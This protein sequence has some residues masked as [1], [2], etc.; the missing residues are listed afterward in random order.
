M[1]YRKKI[2]YPDFQITRDLY[3]RGGE[4]MTT[5]SRE[6]VGPY[7][8][9]TDGSAFTLGSYDEVRSKQLVP[10]VRYAE[11]QMGTYDAI[12]HRK[13][14]TTTPVPPH[15][16]APSP[17]ERSRG[18]LYRYFARKVTD[19]SALVTEVSEKTHGLL[20]GKSTSQAV[21][22]QTVRIVWRIGPP[23][24][25]RVVNGITIPG[26]VDENL[27]AVTAADRNFPGLLA[28]VKNFAEFS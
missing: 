15:V 12:T 28:H 17:E 23:Y 2:Y 21:L 7:H 11:Q 22:Y 3:T 27:R 26:S 6:Y 1:A 9:Y 5:D 18:W 24:N 19:P 13:F 16:P 25:D 10:F 20:S 4:W 8:R 14:R